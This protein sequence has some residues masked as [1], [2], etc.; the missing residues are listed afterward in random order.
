M[1]PPDDP[2][3]SSS[4]SEISSSKSVPTTNSKVAAIAEPTSGM[5]AVILRQLRAELAEERRKR[6][7]LELRQRQLAM[8]LYRVVDE[9][10]RGVKVMRKII[11][12]LREGK[13][14]ET[15]ELMEVMKRMKTAWRTRQPMSKRMKC[16]A[17]KK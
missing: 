8:H 17:K 7:A 4:I 6:E 9:Q 11:Q 14:E 1:L 16:C 13:D 2:D 12:S 5:F 15:E 10:I 3:S